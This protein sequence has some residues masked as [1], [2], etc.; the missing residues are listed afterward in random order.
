M[1][2]QPSSGAEID[3]GIQLVIGSTS[4]IAKVCSFRTLFIPPFKLFLSVL[5]NFP[6]NEVPTCYRLVQMHSALLICSFNEH[7][8]YLD[9]GFVQGK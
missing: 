5:I 7:L 6:F 2:T 9:H 1:I 8:L 3:L 4:V